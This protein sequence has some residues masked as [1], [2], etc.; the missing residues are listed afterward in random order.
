MIECDGHFSIQRFHNMA[1]GQKQ[2]SHA[3]TYGSEQG[4]SMCHNPECLGVI[5][6]FKIFANSSI[7]CIFTQN[8]I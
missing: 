4:D 6:T 7:L 3:L 2:N 8:A 1:Q 5:N